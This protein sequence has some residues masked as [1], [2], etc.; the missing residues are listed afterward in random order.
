MI[1]FSYYFQEEVDEKKDVE[2]ENGNASQRSENGLGWFEEEEQDV[3]G[4]FEIKKKGD[5][6]LA[7]RKYRLEKRSFTDAKKIR[8]SPNV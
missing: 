3:K 8:P 5:G 7:K 2:K 6:V 1:T 4:E